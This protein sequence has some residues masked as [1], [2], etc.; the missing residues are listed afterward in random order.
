M[1]NWTDVSDN[2]IAVESSPKNSWL[3]YSP[4]RVVE[5]SGG[6][7]RTPICW[8]RDEGTASR[9]AALINMNRAL[10]DTDD[11]RAWAEF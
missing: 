9:I 11:S 4:S 5:G 3:I 10:W 8:C 6:H 7:A 2:Y 1:A